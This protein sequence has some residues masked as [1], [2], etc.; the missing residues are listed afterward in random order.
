MSASH[1]GKQS[2][3]TNNLVKV[4]T[5]LPKCAQLNGV[6]FRIAHPPCAHPPLKWQC[7]Q[8]TRGIWHLDELMRAHFGETA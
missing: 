6:R 3:F 2:K 1:A 7:A 4:K 5:V 8:Q